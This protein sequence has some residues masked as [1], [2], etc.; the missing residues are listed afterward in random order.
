MVELASKIKGKSPSKAT[1][2]TSSSAC[3]KEIDDDSSYLVLDMTISRFTN[4]FEMDDVLFEH[5]GGMIKV[6]IIPS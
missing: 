4:V 2:R 3:T 5:V 1:T 6:Q